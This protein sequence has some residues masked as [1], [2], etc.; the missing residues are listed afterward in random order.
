MLDLCG[1][2]VRLKSTSFKSPV[3]ARKLLRASVTSTENLVTSF[4]YTGLKVSVNMQIEKGKQEG[5][6]YWSEQINAE[7][8][9]LWQL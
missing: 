2:S 8:V 5:I 4:S 7:Q 1:K 3:L 9:V 6:S